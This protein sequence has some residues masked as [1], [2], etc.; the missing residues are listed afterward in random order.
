MYNIVETSPPSTLQA[1]RLTC[2]ER[3]W[4]QL[5]QC[6]RVG[7]PDF[8]TPLLWCPWRTT[9]ASPVVVRPQCC[10]AHDPADSTRA[11]F[12]HGRMVLLKLMLHMGDHSGGFHWSLWLSWNRPG[13]WFWCLDIR[14]N[15]DPKIGRNHA[16]S[17]VSKGGDQ[18][19]L[20]VV[21]SFFVN[22]MYCCNSTEWLWSEHRHVFALV[23]T[24]IDVLHQGQAGWT[25]W[26]PVSCCWSALG[27]RSPSAS[28]YSARTLTD[29][30][31][32]VAE[33]F[34]NGRMPLNILKPVMICCNCLGSQILP[35]RAIYHIK[36]VANPLVSYHW[37]YSCHSCHSWHSSQTENGWELVAEFLQLLGQDFLGDPFTSQ[38]DAANS[39]RRKA[40]VLCASGM[41]QSWFRQT[42]ADL[43]LEKNIQ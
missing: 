4:R 30:E 36:V 9:I 22:I 42:S 33:G 34:M 15:W 26:L 27:C 21:S 8:P 16:G 29:S 2:P 38:I 3:R 1:S 14:S 18:I 35:I 5:R 12:G 24:F 7:S 39:W 41:L 17:T 37:I 20:L 31:W 11:L 32:S 10:G 28:F 19:V 6:G 43:G 23:L 40:P 13:I 25:C